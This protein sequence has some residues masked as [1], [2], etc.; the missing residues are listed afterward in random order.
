MDDPR[1]AVGVAPSAVSNLVRS[2]TAHATADRERSTSA[3]KLGD[4]DMF[5]YDSA[6]SATPMIWQQRPVALL[7]ILDALAVRPP[8]NWSCSPPPP[9][10]PRAL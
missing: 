9:P 5:T 4:V 1:D 7:C 8:P 10:P 6:N 3:S 2:G